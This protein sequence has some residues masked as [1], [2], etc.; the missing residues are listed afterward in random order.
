MLEQYSLRPRK[1]D[2]KKEE[3]Y[4][5]K[6]TFLAI[7]PVEKIPAKTKDLEFGGRIGMYAKFLNS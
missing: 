6:K 3:I 5:E 1:E 4:S 7:K 2:K